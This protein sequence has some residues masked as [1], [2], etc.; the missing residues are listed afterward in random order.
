M[1]LYNSYS[2][3]HTITFLSK[4][5]FKFN[6]LTNRNY[7]RIYVIDNYQHKMYSINCYRISVILISEKKVLLRLYKLFIWNDHKTNFLAKDSI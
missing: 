2:K 4:T 1:S 5:N 3:A 6:I 7:F